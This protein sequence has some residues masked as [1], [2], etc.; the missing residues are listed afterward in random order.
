MSNPYLVLGEYILSLGLN[1]TSLYRTSNVL[2]GQLVKRNFASQLG[3]S[4]NLIALLLNWLLFTALLTPYEI[5]MIWV[6]RPQ[7][8]LRNTTVMFWLGTLAY[9]QQFSL[10]VSVFFLTLERILVIKFPLV[11]NARR[12]KYLFRISLVVY[13]IFMIGN[14]AAYIPSLPMPPEKDSCSQFGCTLNKFGGDFYYYSRALCALNNFFTTFALCSEFL[15]EFVPNLAPVL[16]TK[17][18]GKNPF[19]TGFG[20]YALVLCSVEV[21]IFTYFYTTNL[22]NMQKTNAVAPDNTIP[23]AGNTMYK[24]LN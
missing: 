3:I 14:V 7:E 15:F 16:L 22:K 18:I 12:Q 17:I 23:T 2:F 11:H 1:L 8:N 6:W 21:F 13:P 24:D 10:P 4:K 19:A 9:S 5:Y 20:P